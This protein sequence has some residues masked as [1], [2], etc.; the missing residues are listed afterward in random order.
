[1]QKKKNLFRPKTPQ[2]AQPFSFPFFFPAAQPPSPGPVSR[3]RRP[4]R[5]FPLLCRR[6][7]GPAR[8]ARPLPRDERTLAESSRR[9]P[10]GLARTPRRLL[11]ALYKCRG[12]PLYPPGNLPSL[13]RRLYSRNRSSRAAIV[14]ELGA[15]RRTAVPSLPRLQKLPPEHRVVV[16]TLTGPF[17]LSLTLSFPRD[18][19]PTPPF[20]LAPPQA[21]PH[22]L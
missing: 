1:M 18:S 13:S 4:I 22:P 2:P 12:P 11:S 20:R 10:R 7:A 16:R 9:T 15:H 14:A 3:A 19:S 8:R 21:L 5:T 17:S 6:Q